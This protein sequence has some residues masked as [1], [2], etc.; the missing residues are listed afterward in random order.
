M[1]VGFQGI[2]GAYSEL[3]CF[4]YFGKNVDTVPC[5]TF[6]EMFTMLEKKEIDCFV[7]PVE[8]SIEGAVVKA[9]EL[10]LKKYG[11]YVI[12]EHYLRVNHCLIINPEDS[13][14]NIKFVLSHPQA[15]GQCKKFI[16][17]RGLKEIPFFDTAASV[18]EIKGKKGY[19]A[20][21]SRLAA[22]L[23]GMKIVAEKIQDEET[24][25]TRFLIIGKE[26]TKG[27]KHS[28]IFAVEHKP[29]AL[30]KVLEV[31]KNIN[32]TRLV[33]MPSKENPWQ[34]VFFVDFI[35]EEDIEEVI[36]NIASRCIFVK[37]LGSYK[38]E[39]V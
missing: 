18:L 26:K 27:N 16:E 36:K 23:Y 17:A 35:Y 28:V 12:G 1:K 29:G 20:I 19:G 25:E 30:L 10:L 21:A 2:H 38:A 15:L 6:E 34:Y 32:M 7:L 13:I 37:Y 4:E 14:E 33:S 11:F 5:K 31:L 22:E 39:R 8:N 3:C 9:H 24:N